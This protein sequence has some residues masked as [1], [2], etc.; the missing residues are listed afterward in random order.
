V[1][2][3]GRT[4]PGRRQV[5]SRAVAPVSQ[6]ANLEAGGADPKLPAGRGGYRKRVGVLGLRPSESCRR[7][8]SVPAAT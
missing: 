6:F 4:P 8:Q 5:S 1:A 3:P 7:W 2:P